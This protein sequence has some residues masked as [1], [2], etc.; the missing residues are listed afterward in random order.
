MDCSPPGSSVHGIFQARILEW[1]AIFPGN[2][3]DPGIEPRSSALRADALTS[4]P[5]WKPMENTSLHSASIGLPVL[6]ISYKW[7]HAIDGLA[8]QL[9][10][11]STTSGLLR[12]SRISIPLLMVVSNSL[13]P[14][15]LYSPWNSPG[16]N[17]GMGRLP[18]PEDLP[19]PG[20]KPRSPALQAD[21]LPAET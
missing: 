7:S 10:P 11:R 19:N 3:P 16:Q 8:E 1:V 14:H 17:T 21:S 2:L 4:E 6:G 15:G 13:Q 12:C 18:S 9:P 20:I 5:Q